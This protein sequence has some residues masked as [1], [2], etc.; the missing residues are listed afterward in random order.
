MSINLK[1]RRLNLRI[2][3]VYEFS[4]DHNIMDTSNIISTHKYLINKHDIQ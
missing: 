1:K 4:V 3:Y 2:R